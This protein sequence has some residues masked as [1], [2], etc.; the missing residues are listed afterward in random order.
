VLRV[1]GRRCWRPRASE[2]PQPLLIVAL[3][4]RISAA[5]LLHEQSRVAVL[6]PDIELFRRQVARRIGMAAP[7]ARH[8]VHHR[9]SAVRSAVK[10]WEVDARGRI[11]HSNASRPALLPL[12]I[13]SAVAGLPACAI[14]VIDGH[15]RLCGCRAG[16]MQGTADGMVGD[17]LGRQ[18]RGSWWIAHGW[19]LRY[20]NRIRPCCHGV[21]PRLGDC[22]ERRGW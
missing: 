6:D 8:L 7:L 15:A 16:I 20:G 18:R 19:G 13:G 22:R 4:S 21:H 2:E 11:N 12:G 9:R 1:E 3:G 5:P 14:G 10:T 17:Q